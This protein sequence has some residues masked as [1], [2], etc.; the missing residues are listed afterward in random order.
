MKIPKGKAVYV[1]GK[2][3]KGYKDEIPDS[4]I[5]AG[6]AGDELKQAIDK[7]EKPKTPKAIKDSGKP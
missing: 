7:S 3:G 4:K 2:G 5:P 6:K 1:G